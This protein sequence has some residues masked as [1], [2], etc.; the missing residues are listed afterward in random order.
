[1]NTCDFEDNSKN[2]CYDD[3]DKTYMI[4]SGAGEGYFQDDNFDQI[5]TKY[6]TVPI[7]KILPNFFDNFIIKIKNRQLDNQS[8]INLKKISNIIPKFEDIFF[9]KLNK[10]LINN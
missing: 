2:D 1:M 5:M 3:N 8:K 9:N 4:Y 6:C 10:I 7:Y